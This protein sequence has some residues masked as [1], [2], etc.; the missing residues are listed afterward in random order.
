MEPAQQRLLERIYMARAPLLDEINKV[1]PWHAVHRARTLRR[2][3]E[4]LRPSSVVLD[5]AC[6]TGILA[7]QYAPLVARAVLVD[8]LPRMLALAKQSLSDLRP[9]PVVDFVQA[10]LEQLPPFVTA[11]K[12]DVILMTQ[13]LNFVVDPAPLF[14]VAATCLTPNGKLYVDTDTAFRWI[15]IEALSGHIGNAMKIALES[16]DEA[17]NIVGAEYIFHDRDRLVELAESH[18]LRLKRE[19]GICYVS[20]LVHIFNQSSDFLSI[21]RLD[22]RSRPFLQPDVMSQLLALDASLEG[23]LP[24]QSGGW[25]V[26]EFEQQ[27]CNS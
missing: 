2:L 27:E 16:R 6:G 22:E 5:L 11:Q 12:Y 1:A 13:A 26:L 21:Q 18:G 14:R 4:L 24:P 23:I 17:R 19:V 25:L 15:V 10:S 8:L 3:R 20:A 7:R 9:A